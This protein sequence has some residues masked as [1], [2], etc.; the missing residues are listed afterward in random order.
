M[1]HWNEA[2]KDQNMQLMRPHQIYKG[3]RG[4]DY[5]KVDK[6]EEGDLA[7]YL[8]GPEDKNGE[9]SKSLSSETT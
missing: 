2:V 6:R 8:D 5:V 7:P 3:V 1:A 9:H 4:L